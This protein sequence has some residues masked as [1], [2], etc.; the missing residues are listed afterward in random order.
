MLLQLLSSLSHPRRESTTGPVFQRVKLR[1]RRW[2]RWSPVTQKFTCKVGHKSLPPSARPDLIHQATLFSYSLF[3]FFLNPVMILCL[4]SIYNVSSLS[5]SASAL[6]P[7]C[8]SSPGSPSLQVYPILAFTSYPFL[9]KWVLSSASRQILGNS[10]PKWVIEHSCKWIIMEM[11]DYAQ[12][13]K[14]KA[15]TGCF[16]I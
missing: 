4:F 15:A 14:L 7:K 9:S 12:C 2:Y 16:A 6:N 1:T 11:T 8:S 5:S 3:Y 13:R 10:H